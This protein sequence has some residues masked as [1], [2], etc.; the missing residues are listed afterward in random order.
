MNTFNVYLDGTFSYST[1]EE[2]VSSDAA[3]MAATNNLYAACADLE[4]HFDNFDMNVTPANTQPYVSLRTLYESP[5]PSEYISLAS[6]YSP[7]N[8]RYVPFA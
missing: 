1:A 2:A 7:S 6:H 5:P 3:I 4:I 8:Q